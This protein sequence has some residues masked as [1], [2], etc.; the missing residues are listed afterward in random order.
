MFFGD[1]DYNHMDILQRCH[2]E[3]SMN[4]LNVIKKIEMSLGIE[5]MVQNIA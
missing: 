4:N 3:Y 5:I 1:T 2:T